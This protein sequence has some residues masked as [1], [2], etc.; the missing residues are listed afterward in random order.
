MYNKYIFSFWE[1]KDNMPDYL[2]LC[3][4]T[5]KQFMPEYEIVMLDYKNIWDWLEEDIFYKKLFK[6]FSLPKQ[7]DVIRC[8]VLHKYGGVWFDTDTILVNESINSLVKNSLAQ[9]EICLTETP[10]KYHP[11]TG[12]IFAVKGSEIMHQ[13]VVAAEKRIQ[14][15]GK[16]KSQLILTKIF[17]NKK[18]KAYKN[19]DFLGNAILDKII[20]G[21]DRTR[22]LPFYNDDIK[23]FPETIKYPE[24]TRREAYC[25][26]WFQD[27][28]SLSDLSPDSKVIC[29]HN[30]WTPKEYCLMNESEFLKQN[31]TLSHVLKELM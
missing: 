23:A 2:K 18:Y 22:Y 11:Y 14:E 13:C 7:S 26:F 20:D 5:W 4:N 30:S 16:P 3:V 31:I 1:P 27:N 21:K 8:A 25:K 9:A 29:L 10:I 15:F 12:M 17:N 19:W 6:Y 24:L 28:Y